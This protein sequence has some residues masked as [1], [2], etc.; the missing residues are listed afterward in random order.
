MIFF[1]FVG[2][3]DLGFYTYAAVCTENAARLASLQ[4]ASNPSAPVVTS[5]SLQRGHI[6]DG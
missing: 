2:V 1:L 3:F 5:F 6:G 4:T